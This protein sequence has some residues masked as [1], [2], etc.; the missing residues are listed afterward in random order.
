MR[1]NIGCSFLWYLL[2]VVPQQ[3]SAFTSSIPGPRNVVH[4]ATATIL[5]A[6]TEGNSNEPESSSKIDNLSLVYNENSNRRDFFKQTAIL[7]SGT[8]ASEMLPRMTRAETPMTLQTASSLLSLP[9][10]GLGKLTNCI[11]SF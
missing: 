8:V 4:E 10:M 6:S 5:H 9:P 1:F 3:S 2:V 7:S 11:F